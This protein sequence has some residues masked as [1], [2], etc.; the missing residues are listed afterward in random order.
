MQKNKGVLYLIPNVISDNTELSVLNNQIKYYISK[1]NIYFVENIRNARR[2]I[3]KVNRDIDID[4]IIFISIGKHSKLDINNDFILPIVSGDNVGIISE[5]GLPC[6][7]DPGFDIVRVAHDLEIKVVPMVGPSSIFMTL[8]AS[9][10][11]GQNFTFH[12]YLPIDKKELKNKIK[13]LEY[14]SKKNIQ[15][16]IFIETPYRNMKLFQDL[17]KMCDNETYLCIGAEVTGKEERIITKKIK[18]WK[19]LPTPKIHK[20]P[21]VFILLS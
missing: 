14:I 1:I 5:S 18:E 16:Q 7:A 13:Q 21:S 11:N 8:M 2:Y 19:L 15:S 9:G 20:I 4:K 10:L 12:G 17:I 3:R 6:I